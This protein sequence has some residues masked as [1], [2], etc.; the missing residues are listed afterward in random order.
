MEITDEDIAAAEQ[1]YEAE[2]RRGHVTAARYDS[3]TGNLVLNLHNGEEVDISASLLEGLRGQGADALAEVEVTPGG[4]GLYWPTLDV[5]LYVPG[6]LDGVFGTKR[7][8]NS[9]FG[10]DWSQAKT[11]VKTKPRVDAVAAM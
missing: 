10:E 5:D 7:W 1:A 2:R 9:L 6:L 11:L 4:L 3:R 8:M